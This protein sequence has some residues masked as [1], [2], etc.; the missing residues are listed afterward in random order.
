MKHL[1]TSRLVYSLVLWLIHAAALSV[2]ANSIKGIHLSG[3]GAALAASLVLTVANHFLLPVLT[4]LTLPL[5]ILTLGI[6]WIFLYGAMLKLAAALIPGFS[7]T[8][9][10]PAIIGAIFLAIVHGLF[11]VAFRLVFP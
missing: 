3:F 6:F 1:D 8:G 7:V 10:F 2:T 4:I 5:T 11:R 9:W